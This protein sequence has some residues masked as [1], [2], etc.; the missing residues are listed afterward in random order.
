MDLTEDEIAS[1]TDAEREAYLAG[2]EDEDAL[3]QLAG[4]D[5]D[6]GTAG[7]EGKGADDAG[8]GADTGA[9]TGAAD[10]EP[11]DA[12]DEPRA[13]FEASV[14]ADA[15]E[16]RTALEA[17]KDEA[18]QKLMDGELTAE[19]YRAEEKAI[20]AELRTLDAAELEAGISTKMAQQQMQRDW[21]RYVNAEVARV[22]PQLDIRANE[23][24]SAELD[25]TVRLLAQQLAHDKGM[26]AAAAKVKPAN[27]VSG[28]DR[29]C[30]Q[31]AMAI[32]LARHGRAT[33]AGEGTKPAPR[34]KAD[35]T[36]VPPTL[37]NLPVASEPGVSE[38]EFA[39]LAGLKGDD[40]ERAIAAMT[41]DQR[42]R[43]MAS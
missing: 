37:A 34:P 17:R 21:H 5:D 25:R 8:K 6:T 7:D 41:P 29:Y 12:D 30:L 35:L 32:V 31:E 19:Q 11:A 2:V 4:G 42:N 43:F 23:D 27:G 28:A 20:A 13:P 9:D 1:L 14:P 36:K 39:H 16:Q 33:P 3:A 10:D 15:A 26:Q 38:D 40:Y 24:V 18:F 22:K